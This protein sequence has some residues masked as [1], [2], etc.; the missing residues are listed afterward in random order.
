MKHNLKDLSLK[1]A[2]DL[3]IQ[4]EL[5]AK[6]RYEEFNRQIG[7][8]ANGD[9]GDFFYQMSLNEKKHADDLQQ[10]RNELFGHSPSSISLEDL[11][12][13]QEIEAPSFDKSE[14]FMSVKKAL[15]VARES[16]VKAYEF[17]HKAEAL[18]TDV[19]VKALFNELKQE[20]LEHKKMVEDLLAKISPG[21]EQPL[22]DKNDVD[23]PNGL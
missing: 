10:K 21:D 13:L 16:E 8:Q 22:V 14:S 12:H 1:E 3:A 6:A 18:V 2:L 4:V 11:Y 9:A 19:K 15:L 20:E 7:S 17:F 23:E 5:E